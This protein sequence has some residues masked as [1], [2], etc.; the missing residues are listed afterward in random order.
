MNRLKMILNGWDCSKAFDRWGASFQTK[1][2]E[3]PNSG[4]SM[5]G[6]TIV[7]LVKTK[8]CWTLKGNGVNTETYA[9]LS[10]LCRHDYITAV[11]VHP[12]TLQETTKVMIPSLSSAVR[13]PFPDGQAW[14]TGWTLTLEER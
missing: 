2:V 14:F 6:S 12:E 8:D 4:V 5:G 3:G 10:A 1:R 11:Y 9:R 13:T 7:D